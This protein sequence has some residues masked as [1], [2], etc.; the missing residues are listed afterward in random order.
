MLKAYLPLGLVCLAN[1]V[2]LPAN[3]ATLNLV[4]NGSF[5]AVEL[6]NGFIGFEG[7][8][9]PNP[10]GALFFPTL[11]ANSGN[12]AASVTNSSDFANL[13]QILATTAGQEYELSFFLSISGFSTIDTERQN[14]FTSDISNSVTSR[15]N[16][17]NPTF[18]VNS[19]AG[20][21]KLTEFFIATSNFSTLSFQAKN[22]NGFTL[23]DDVSVTAVPVPFEFNPI[24]G[25]TVIGSLW[26]GKKLI[27]KKITAKQNRKEV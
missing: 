1:L 5:E 17:N 13:S 3:A 24:L 19:R 8:N 7:W 14:S 11:Q 2:G 21:V 16:L 25:M 23:L 20:Y 12:F 18:N 10:S 22:P 26:F 9:N 6:Q 27:K 15:R 4:T